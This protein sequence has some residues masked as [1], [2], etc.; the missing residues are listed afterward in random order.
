MLS[1]SNKQKIAS[2]LKAAA[3]NMLADSMKLRPI[4]QRRRLPEAYDNPILL[5]IGG[6]VFSVL[7]SHMSPDY[8]TATYIVKGRHRGA[9]PQQIEASL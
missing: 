9:K 8:T 1:L 3:E 4:P 6:E 5:M 7:W 2:A